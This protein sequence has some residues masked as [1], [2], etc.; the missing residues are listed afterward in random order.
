M[1]TDIVTISHGSNGIRI[2]H[3]GGYRLFSNV[4]YLAEAHANAM[5]RL[6]RYETME[7]N[8]IEIH[9]RLSAEIER[10]GTS[11]AEFCAVRDMLRDVMEQ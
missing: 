2:Q 3:G 7:R 8:L 10:A 11:S 1:K 5:V 9:R 4:E 6:D